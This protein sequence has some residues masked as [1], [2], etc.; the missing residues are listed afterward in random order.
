MTNPRLKA[1]ADQLKAA[2]DRLESAKANP[3]QMQQAIAEARKQADAVCKE[4]EQP[5]QQG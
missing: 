1:A 3:G 5:Q 4:A 2:L